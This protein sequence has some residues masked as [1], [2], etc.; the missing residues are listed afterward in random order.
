MQSAH[1]RIAAAELIMIIEFYVKC[2][3]TQTHSYVLTCR[4]CV[5]ILFGCAAEK[6]FFLSRS[7][8]NK[9]FTR[10]G[11]GVGSKVCL[12]DALARVPEM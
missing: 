9:R 4:L 12:F 7:A 2:T 3:H 1:T 8:G 5:H 6:L 10:T 11:G